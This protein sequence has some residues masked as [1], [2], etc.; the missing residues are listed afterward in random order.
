MPREQRGAA[1]EAHAAQCLTQ[2]GLRILAQNLRFPFGEIDILAAEGPHLVFVEVR[3]RSSMA[4][5]GPAE[6]VTPE[7]QRRLR[8][9]AAA[10]L[11]RYGST[12]P[13]RW[14]AIW[15]SPR[16]TLWQRHLAIGATEPGAWGP[17]GLRRRTRC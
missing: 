14:D 10:V 2:A 17:R 1:A 8:L 3:Y 9:A 12:R 7:K 5:G 6:S 4:Y 11:Q 16:Q 13:C 15:A